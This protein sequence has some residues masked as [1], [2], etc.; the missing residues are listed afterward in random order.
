MELLNEDQILE[1]KPQDVILP[2]CEE[3]DDEGADKVLF[4]VACFIDDLLKYMYRLEGYYNLAK[5]SELV[6]HLVIGLAPHISA[7]I[8]GRIIG[9]SKT[10]GCYAHPLWHSAQRRDCDGDE[11][12][13]M[14][15]LDGLLN[16]SKAVDP[17]STNSQ[18]ILTP[19]A[20]ITRLAASVTS[21]P[22]PSPGI[23]VMV[24]I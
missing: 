4:R 9:F 22:I 19:A 11:T 20:S 13:V 3:S 10:Q 21:G 15:L 2:S 14:L 18:L 8:V 23:R 16:F 5:P 17:A 1:L 24:L 12:C 6:G 7:G